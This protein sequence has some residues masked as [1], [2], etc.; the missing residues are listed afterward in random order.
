MLSCALGPTLPFRFIPESFPSFVRKRVQRCFCCFRACF[1]LGPTLPPRFLPDKVPSYVH[2]P[3]Q[4]KLP[5]AL[6]PNPPRRLS[7]I[8]LYLLRNCTLARPVLSLALGPTLPFR[9]IPESF[10]SFVHKRVQRSFCCFRACFVLG[11]T[12]P[13]R[14]LPDWVPSYVHRPVQCKLPCALDPNPPSLPS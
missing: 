11:P 10:P 8:L 1:A 13:P 6:G 2:R 14:F 4:C 9:F 5:C 3:V 12:L 7:P